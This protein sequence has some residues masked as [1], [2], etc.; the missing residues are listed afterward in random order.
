MSRVVFSWNVNIIRR[1][2]L[3][4]P[5]PP[6][7]PR[8]ARAVAGAILLISLLSFVRKLGITNA[9]LTLV[10]SGNWGLFLSAMFQTQADCHVVQRI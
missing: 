3:V 10:Q 6:R 8:L 1:H 7:S 9:L 2:P 4:T 5:A